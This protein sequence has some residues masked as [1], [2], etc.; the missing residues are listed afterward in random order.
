MLTLIVPVK[1]IESR[2][3]HGGKVIARTLDRSCRRVLIVQFPT[4]L[5]YWQFACQNNLFQAS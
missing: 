3:C 4:R 1:L 2:D 5:S